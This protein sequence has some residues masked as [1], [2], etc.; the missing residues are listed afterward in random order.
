VTQLSGQAKIPVFAQSETL[1]FL[2]VADAQL[3]F[4]KGE[5]G[6]YVI[7]HQNGRDQK[8]VKKSDTVEERKEIAVPRMILER[9]LGTYEL[10]PGFDLVVTLEGD[11]LMTQATGQEKFPIFAESETKFFLKV[12]DAEIEFSGDHLILHQGVRDMPTKRK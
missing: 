1:F 6:A 2:K 11:Q 5:K 10:Q 12:V 3:E 8:A 4:G 9:Y 7:L